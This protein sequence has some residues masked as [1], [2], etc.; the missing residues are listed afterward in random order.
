MPPALRAGAD[1]RPITVTDRHGE[2]LYRTGADS[3]GMRLPFASIPP[4]IV[5]ALLS[6]EDRGFFV[7]RGV[8][9]RGIARSIVANVR[10]G[11]IVSGGSTLT[12]QLVRIRLAPKKRGWAFKIREALLALKLEA[13]STKHGILEN[14]LNEAFFGHGASGIV[15]ASQMYFG[16]HPDDL[17]AAE[18]ALLIGLLRSPGAL[19]PY[20][21]AEGALRRRDTVLRIMRD[22]GILSEEEYL[23]AREL[24]LHLSHG[25]TLIT[26]PHFVMWVLSSREVGADGVVMTTLDS[27]LQRKVEG[28]VE[29]G[30]AKLADR[31]VTSAAVVVLDARS[32]DVLGMVGSA[33]Y[34]D[35]EHDGQ[36]NV[37]VSARQPGSAL[38]PFTYA[39]ALERGDTAATTVPDTDI[40]LLTQEGNPYVPRNYDYEHHGLVRYREAL[41][42]SYNIAAVKVLEKVG[43]ERLLSLLRSAGITTLTEQ[44]E[45][46]GLALTLGSG[47]VKLLELAAAFGVFAR[48]GRTL[49]PR[50]VL[51][52]PPSPDGEPLMSRQTAWLISDILSDNSARI[53]EFGLESP[54]AFDFPVAA[55]TGT[56]RNARDNWVVGYTPDRIV[57]VWVGNADNSP[58]KGTSG[59]TGAG[60]IF[61]DVML[62]AHEGISPRDFAKPSGIVSVEICEASGKL[63]TP[64]CPHTVSEFFMRGTEPT[65]TD[66][67]FRAID[68]DRRNG[69]LASPECDRRFVVSRVFAVYP[70]ELASWARESGIEQPPVDVSPLC[71]DAEGTPLRSEQS[72]IEITDPQ[73]GDSF[74]FDPLVPDA[75]EGISLRARASDDVR[76]I[77]WSANGERIGTAQAPDFLLR[78]R[79][80]NAGMWNIEA[81]SGSAEASLT[82]EV[83]P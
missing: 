47:E 32:G 16:K 45:H 26:A 55:K 49:T 14:Y 61:H 20:I 33:D 35:A 50:A 59:V 80:P 24:P 74:V 25:K 10:G 82:F 63:P 29:R 57:G 75:S 27:D 8:S 7:H 4:R 21:N 62:A 1:A 71:A 40:H 52:D 78:F 81:R 13:S 67:L 12:Q 68:I 72:F 60:P 15:A 30:L 2:P 41:A 65:E 38:K 19:D 6:V 3:V 9:V 43:P 18:I 56:T 11:R 76:S 54:L 23:S 46:Y 44:S 64:E 28:V 22:E 51:T 39:L 79:P 17:S 66:D 42:N 31:N 48:E 36:V 53:A 34:F 73:R 5:A 58:M 37:A 69:L 77:V 83:V 70:S